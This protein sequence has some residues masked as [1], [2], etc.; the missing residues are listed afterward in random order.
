MLIVCPTCASQYTIDPARVGARG[1]T[2]RCAACRETWFVRPSRPD[3]PAEE[4]G[5]GG[6]AAPARDE[7]R[8]SGTTA[9][10]E[11]ITVAA[12]TGAGPPAEA[13][14]RAR[15]GRREAPVARVPAS[16]FLD[17]RRAGLALVGAL[18]VLGGIIAARAEIARVL[19]PTARLFAA[20]GLPVNLRGLAFTGLRAETVAG[21]EGAALEVEATVANLRGAVTEVPPLEIAV[22]G[23][24]GQPL[25]TW[26][27]APPRP[28]LAAS[29]SMP[30]RARLASP[31]PEGRQVS[32]R[33][34]TA[35][36]G[37][38]GPDDGAP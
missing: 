2:V 17:A 30:V 24:D 25:Y 34:A 20:I 7:A 12:T 18:V 22:Q 8:S 31:P 3:A 19:P 1:R 23:A 13:P 38:D 9:P 6:A 10:A 16:A 27:V 32:I 14:R 33:F 15:R 36:K 4:A 37:G 21:A 5:P 29:D 11:A 28:S 26:T 35:G